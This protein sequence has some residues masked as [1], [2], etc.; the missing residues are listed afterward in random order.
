MLIKV[1]CLN[2]RQLKIVI[3]SN[4]G[5][6]YAAASTITQLLCKHTGW[7]V[8]QDKSSVITFSVDHIF[9]FTKEIDY[10]A[11]CLFTAAC[12]LEKTEKVTLMTST[13]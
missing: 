2:K 8:Y 4:G 10:L 13:C 11:L 12:N 5:Q 9:F 3:E 6:G 1:V 7:A